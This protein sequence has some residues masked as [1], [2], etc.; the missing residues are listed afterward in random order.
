MSESRCWK[1]KIGYICCWKYQNL[2]VIMIPVLCM[3]WI[4]E[5][6]T[7]E[8]ETDEEWKYMSEIRKKTRNE[9]YSVIFFLFAYW[10]PII[11]NYWERL[12]DRDSDLK[13]AEDRETEKEKDWIKLVHTNLIRKIRSNSNKYSISFCCLLVIAK[14][15]G[16]EK[17]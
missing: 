8:G 4:E 1:F 6:E 7:D 16:I 10:K 17:H 5:V 15:N 9:V 11:T 12:R 14:F 13:F 3:D 2:I